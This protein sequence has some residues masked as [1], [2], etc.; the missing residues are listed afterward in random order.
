MRIYTILFSLLLFSLILQGQNCY[1][2]CLNRKLIDSTKAEIYKS[3][4]LSK[5][6][7]DENR[8]Q[9]ISIQTVD[10]DI[11]PNHFMPLLTLKEN[12]DTI[13]IPNLKKKFSN[14]YYILEE[15]NYEKYI[16]DNEQREIAYRYFRE[17]T[18]GGYMDTYTFIRVYRPLDNWINLYLYLS[19]LPDGVPYEI[20]PV[21]YTRIKNNEEI[22]RKYMLYEVRFTKEGEIKSVKV[23]NEI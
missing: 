9:L 4:L 21:L 5:E 22:E 10:L 12:V 2:K 19:N 15:G 23:V 11:D 6:V 14:N 13:S 16:R 1:N 3:L 17:Y 20:I 7:K 18:S 8:L